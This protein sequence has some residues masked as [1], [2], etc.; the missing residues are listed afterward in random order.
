M[1]LFLHRGKVVYQIAPFRT[2]R[3]KRH[4]LMERVEF[5]PRAFAPLFKA[6]LRLLE[7][8]HLSTEHTNLNAMALIDRTSQ[9][10]NPK[11]GLRILRRHDR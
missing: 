3:L 7:L 10:S 5:S 2:F 4:T 11:F 1:L 9:I 8:L 6:V